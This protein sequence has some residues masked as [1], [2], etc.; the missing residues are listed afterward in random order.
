MPP[1]IK[2]MLPF[3]HKNNS[4][5]EKSPTRIVHFAYHKMGTVWL[6]RVLEAVAQRWRLTV[7][8]SNL[9][10]EPIVAAAAI[11]VCNH[12]QHLSTELDPLRGNVVASHLI[13]DP[14]DAIVSGYF[15][16][17]WTNESW[18]HE[19][20]TQFGGSSYQQHLKSI[21]QESGIAAEIERFGH[22][23]HEYGLMEWNY[24]DPRVLELKYE[25]LIAD[26]Q[27]T[28]ER[29]FRHYRFTSRAVTVATKLALQQ[30]F[31]KAT[32]RNL[33]QASPSSRPS[34]LRSGQPGEWKSVLSTEH[35]RQFKNT[36]GDL[37]IHMGYET[38]DDWSP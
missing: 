18:V 15:Y 36:C 10:D 13:R 7:Q 17:L 26:E 25:T 27:A 28:F 29:L 35:C 11:L 24:H 37:L 20:Q 8:K 5:F 6:T 23:V 31:S 12:S 9:T 1:T 30:S 32:N 21:D 34:H 22:Y 4:P 2:L 19:P 33:G 3:T 38:N 16:H 14:R